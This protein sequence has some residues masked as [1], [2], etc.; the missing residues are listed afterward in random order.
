M[1][2]IFSI[3]YVSRDQVIAVE[4]VSSSSQACVLYSVGRQVVKIQVL[5]EYLPA[6]TTRVP[7]WPLAKIQVLTWA[8]LAQVLRYSDTRRS[9][10]IVVMSC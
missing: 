10:V 4:R 1:N 3:T 6:K 2:G 5:P 8:V 9:D 7:T